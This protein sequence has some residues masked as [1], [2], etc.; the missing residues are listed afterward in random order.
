MTKYCHQ[1][2]D[3]TISIVSS[4]TNEVDY[5]LF[6]RSHIISLQVYRVFRI[7]KNGRRYAVTNVL[8]QYMEHEIPLSYPVQSSD[9]EM[10]L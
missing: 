10:I 3:V 2:N 9:V 4:A 8:I 6:R 5:R 1:S 7:P